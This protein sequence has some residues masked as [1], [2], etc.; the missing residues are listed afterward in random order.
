MTD[1][2]ARQENILCFIA[3]FKDTHGYA[4]TIQEICEGTEISSKSIVHRYLTK[5]HKEGFIKRTPRKAR[6]M[7]VL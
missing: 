5:L 4:P 3:E 6:A 1:P 2:A 7:V